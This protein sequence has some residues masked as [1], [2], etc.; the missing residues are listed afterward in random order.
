MTLPIC[1]RSGDVVEPMLKQQWFLDCG[2]MSKKAMDVVADGRLEFQ[3]SFHAKIW[4]H[5][6]AQQRDWCISR[7]LWWGHRIPAYRVAV[8]MPSSAAPSS[9]EGESWVA[10]HT[11]EE[12]REKAA[13]EFGVS[14]PSQ[15]ALS[16]DP[17]VLDTWFSS[18]LFPFSALGWPDAVNGETK[19]DAT[20]TDAEGLFPLSVME[21]GHDI[22]FFW[23][24]RMVMLG[25][26]LT[27][28]LP[29]Q[30]VLLHGMVRRSV[31]K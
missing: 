19:A 5:F 27:N 16:R 9:S 22:L 23:V 17:D 3:P 1:S 14:S 11:E 18:A 25:M 20:W 12:A 4:N 24:A 15:L 7:Q 30:K 28:T 6:L 21:T 8:C 29:F 10:A 26:Q 13:R 2:H 31:I